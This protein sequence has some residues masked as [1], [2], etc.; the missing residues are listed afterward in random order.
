MLDTREKK[1]KKSLDSAFQST[2]FLVHEKGEIH[3]L[4]KNSRSIY[5]MGSKNKNSEG[6]HENKT[7]YNSKGIYINK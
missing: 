4:D 1:K 5:L 6:V 2:C 3:N 7:G